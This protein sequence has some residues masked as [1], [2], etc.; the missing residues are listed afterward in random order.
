MLTKKD[1]IA[2]LKEFHTRVW[3]EQKVVGKMPKPLNLLRKAIERITH[4][5]TVRRTG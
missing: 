5:L 3:V 4:E 2:K 1:R